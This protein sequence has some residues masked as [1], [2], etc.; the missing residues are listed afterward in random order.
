[1]DVRKG[2]GGVINVVENPVD[3]EPCS[4]GIVQEYFYTYSREHDYPETVVV[5]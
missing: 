2:K 3:S 4:F 1:M 5:E